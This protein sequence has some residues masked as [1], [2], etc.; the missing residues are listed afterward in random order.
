[1]NTARPALRAVFEEAGVRGHVFARD[2]DGPAALGLDED[3]PVVLASVFKIPVALAYAR[4]AAAGRLERTERHPVPPPLRDGGIGT[5]GCADPV[6]L[7]LRDLVLLMLTMSDNA[8]TDVV[9]HR[10]GLDRVNALLAG[11]GRDRTHLI[12]GCADLIGSLLAD[13][14]AADEEE[15]QARLAA[16]TPAQT[17]ALSVCVPERTTRGTARDTAELLAQIW[18]DE[19]GP[20]EACAEVRA[21]MGRQIWPHRLSSGFEDGYRIAGKTGTLPGWRN[22]AGVVE[23]PDGGRYAVAVFTRAETPRQRDPGA[24]RAI[25]RAARIAVDA[26]RAT[27]PSTPEPSSVV[28]PPTV[29]A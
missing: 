17:M 21:V 25:G 2:I 14:G 7:S 5:S 9:L 18:R 3:T 12:G 19:A 28:N 4:E 22:E 10:V 11:L 24:D 26:L 1:M 6:E 8:A 13:L 15:A 23:H 20:A 29:T 16:L 27:A